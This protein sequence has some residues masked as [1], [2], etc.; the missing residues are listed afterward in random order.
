LRLS[1]VLQPLRVVAALGEE[2]VGG[3]AVP[4]LVLRH[5]GGG[6]PALQGGSAEHPVGVADAEEALVVGQREDQLAQ[7]AAGLGG[8]LVGLLHLGRGSVVG[9]RLGHRSPPLSARSSPPYEPAPAEW[10]T[11]SSV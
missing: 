3:A 1:L 9:H 6:G 11:A 8:E 2:R 7:R 4:P 5:G 10:I